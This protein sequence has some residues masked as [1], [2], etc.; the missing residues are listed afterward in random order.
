MAQAEALYSKPSHVP[1][2][3]IFGISI[4]AGR[5]NEVT[6]EL[7]SRLA[8]GERIKL[9]YLNAHASNVAAGDPEFLSA[10]QHF[11]ILN[12]GVGLDIAARTFN[13]KAFPENLNGTD[14]TLRFLGETSQHFRI[15][16]LGARPGVAEDAAETIEAMLPQ[17]KV[18]GVRDGYFVATGAAEV[19][20]EIRASGADLLLV[21]LGNPGQELW[22]ERN[23][24]A[25]N[26]RMAIGVGA[27]FDF[28]ARRMPRAPQAVRRLRLEWAFRLALEPS[29]LWRRYLIGNPLFLARVMREL[30]RRRAVNGAPLA[31][32]ELRRE[33]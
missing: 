27:L 2:W 9:T 28:L 32:R 1:R 3:D 11:S 25:T 24:D 19:A 18:V 7:D 13:G 30:P 21:A 16:L 33:T 4:L 17:H 22:I 26:C 8:T 29:R 23:F 5:A 14:F 31:A 10:L 20:A 12:D 6:C 15:F